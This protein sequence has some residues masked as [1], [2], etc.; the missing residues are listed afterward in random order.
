VSGDRDLLALIYSL[1][2]R[3]SRRQLSFT[4]DPLLS[5]DGKDFGQIAVIPRAAAARS[6]ARSH[7]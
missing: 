3:S 5:F 4:D 1:V 2:S 7:R 6:A